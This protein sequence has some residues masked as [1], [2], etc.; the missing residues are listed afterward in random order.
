M[1]K[2]VIL[3][4][5]GLRNATCGMIDELE[6]LGWSG[7]IDAF[8][9]PR[10]QGYI[11]KLYKGCYI[12]DTRQNEEKTCGDIYELNS[13]LQSVIDKSKEEVAQ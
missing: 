3:E 8:A 7:K 13:F 11:V 5:D 6:N 1:K 12:D 9:N 4:I 2:G 10:Y